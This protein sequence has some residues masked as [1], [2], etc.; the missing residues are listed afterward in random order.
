[1]DGDGFALSFNCDGANPIDRKESCICQA[2]NSVVDGGVFRE[3][4]TERD[5]VH[6]ST[7]VKDKVHKPV[8]NYCTATR[9]STK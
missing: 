9:T 7:T 5:H 3:T 2:H 6:S 1:M 8:S 4:S